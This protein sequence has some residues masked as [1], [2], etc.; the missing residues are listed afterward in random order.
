[1]RCKQVKFS[2]CGREQAERRR[3]KPGKL[4]QRAADEITADFR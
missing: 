4:I 1:M 2:E 3:R